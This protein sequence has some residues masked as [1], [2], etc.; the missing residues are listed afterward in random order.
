MQSKS[1]SN[2]I[3]L[4]MTGTLLMNKI[5]S[6]QVNIDLTIIRQ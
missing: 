4:I 2:K 3:L 5:D 6:N 1:G